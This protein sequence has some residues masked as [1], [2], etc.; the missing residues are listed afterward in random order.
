MGGDGGNVGKRRLKRARRD[1]GCGQ[2]GRQILFKR[3]VHQPPG[4]CRIALARMPCWLCRML[5]QEAAPTRANTGAVSRA[6]VTAYPQAYAQPRWTTELVTF[7]SK[8][9]DGLR[10]AGARI[11][12]PTGYDSSQMPARHRLGNEPVPMRS[13]RRPRAGA[14]ESSGNPAA[15]H[16]ARHLSLRQRITADQPGSTHET[17]TELCGSNGVRRRQAS[18]VRRYLAAATERAPSRQQFAFRPR[19]T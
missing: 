4:R 15:V 12:E 14:L 16:G 7:T 5:P 11:C 19:R 3:T 1:R 8:H 13:L 18:H 6:E 2:H 10:C 17:R 9:A